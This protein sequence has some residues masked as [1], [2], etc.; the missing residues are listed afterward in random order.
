MYPRDTQTYFLSNTTGS[1]IVKT[2]ILPTSTRTI[3]SV[4]GNSRDARSNAVLCGNTYI[5]QQQ[6]NAGWFSSEMNYVCTQAVYTEHFRTSSLRVNYVARD[7]TL[8]VDPNREATST[9]SMGS[10]TI[11]NMSASTTQ[12]YETNLT[13]QNG[14]IMALMWCIAFYGIYWLIRKF[15]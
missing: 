4:S 9:I 14:L 8:T 3:L 10:T 11:Q 6:Q 15:W 12:M 7:R 5:S 1:D 13:L 2:L